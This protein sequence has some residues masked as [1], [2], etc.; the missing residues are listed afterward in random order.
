[1]GARADAIGLIADRL[2]KLE[3]GHPAR[4]AVDG[5]TA[6]GKTTLANELAAVVTERGRPAHRLSMDGYHHRRAH[7]HRR[8]RDSADGYYEDA[9][10]FPEFVRGVLV[11]LGPG[12]SREYRRRIIDLPTDEPIDEP[13]VL[14]EPDAIL[15]VDGSFLQRPELAAHWDLVVFVH[16]SFAAAKDRGSRRDARAFGGVEPARAAFDTRYHAA[17]RRYLTEV[18]PAARADI[19]IGN[20]TIDEPV[21]EWI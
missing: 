12:G 11:P 15:I 6:A 8:G 5:I 21:I 14:A 2:V 19:V 18:D 9:Y 7:R 1:M 13:P 3:P 16:T 10:N 20:D 4:I 17:S